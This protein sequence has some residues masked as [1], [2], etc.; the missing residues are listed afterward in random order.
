MSTAHL[1]LWISLAFIIYTY[2][3]YPAII[4]ILSGILPRKPSGICDAA[5]LSISIVISVRNEADRIGARL[6]ELSRLLEQSGRSAGLIV[7][8]DGSTDGTAQIA[9][10]LGLPGVEV[11]ELQ[12]NRGKAHA[13][14]VGVERAR[15]DIVV[16][17][18]A[19]QQW[20]DAALGALVGRFSDAG[21]S[22][23]S[24]DLVIRDAG[25]VVAG[26]GLYWK[27]EKWIRR[28]EG[29]FRSTVG[30]SG[31]ISAV[32]RAQFRSI[33]DGIVLDDLWWPLDVIMRGGRTVHEEAAIAYDIAAKPSGE[34][35]R[36]VRTLAGN[37]QLVARMPATL[38]P[39]RNPIWFEFVSHKLC[40]LLVPWALIATFVLSLL[41]NGQW[42]DYFFWAQVA[43]YV[44]AAF[45]LLF[46]ERLR[47]PLAS[48][49]G[50]FVLL[51][52]AAWCA[53]WVWIG[54]RTGQ[55]WQPTKYAAGK[56][57]ERA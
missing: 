30:V 57:D 40:R 51:N 25:G 49:A 50:S 55:A 36:K 45:S 1:T 8:S 13:I 10:S 42:I 33:P 7:V 14:S 20:D 23:V 35:R 21:V 17:A 39:W 31:S 3:G 38:V 22:A 28:T 6:R 46:G 12:P 2:I 43:F 9:R 18:D 41:G 53:W 56:P 5:R 29:R 4:A 19:R 11:V 52:A 16:F 44:L 54:G 15:G 34:F 47:L 27:Y 37:F 26:V 24:G 32:R 48:A